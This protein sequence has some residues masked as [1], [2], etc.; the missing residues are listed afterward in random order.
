M[1]TPN[2]AIEVHSRLTALETK[3]DATI[4]GMVSDIG[5]VKK[6]MEILVAEHNQRKGARKLFG[7]MLT[8][9]GALA[10]WKMRNPH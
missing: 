8:G 7:V 5:E 1:E 2:D 9:L 3:W 4:P 10:G 6:G